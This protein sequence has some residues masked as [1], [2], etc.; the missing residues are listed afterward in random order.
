M[1]EL[2][3]MVKFVLE[4][5]KCNNDYQFSKKVCRYALF[6]N[7][8]I[9]LWMFVPCDEEGN[10]LTEPRRASFLDS[11]S[12]IVDLDEQL[13]KYNKAKERVLFENFELVEKHKNW[14]DLKVVFEDFDLEVSITSGETIEDLLTHSLDCGW[15]LSKN[16]IKNLG[17]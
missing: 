17:L 6:L 7:Q 14:F 11:P 10:V 3:S 2:I 13:K 15:E 1:T 5:S 12:V 8:L 9:E 16:A 4:Q